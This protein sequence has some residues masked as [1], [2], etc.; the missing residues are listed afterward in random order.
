MKIKVQR[1]CKHRTPNPSIMIE[2][3]I[4]LKNPTLL[5]ALEYIKSEV[6][7]TLALIVDVEVKFVEVVQ[8]G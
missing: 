1:Y 3:D 6:D 4:P 5:E 2:Y 7:Q 8:L